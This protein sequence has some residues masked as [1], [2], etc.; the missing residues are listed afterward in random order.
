MNSYLS[1]ATKFY[2]KVVLIATKHRHLYE[3]FASIAN[4][5]LIEMK[6]ENYEKALKYLTDACE[7]FEKIGK[8]DTLKMIYENMA[9]IY[10]RLGNHDLSNIFYNKMLNWET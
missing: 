6:C 3:K 8:R 9:N 2:E 10:I 4:I 1:R 7:Y 5:G